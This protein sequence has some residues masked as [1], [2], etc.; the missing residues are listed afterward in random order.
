MDYSLRHPA[1]HVHR[2]ARFTRERRLCDDAAVGICG[3]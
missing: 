1:I 2:R 3:I